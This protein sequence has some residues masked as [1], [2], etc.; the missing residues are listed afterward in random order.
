MRRLF[1]PKLLVL[2]VLGIVATAAAVL[3]GL[4]QYDAWQAGRALAA[5]DLATARPVPLDTV[6]G[7]DATFQG[8][9]VGRPVSLT[10]QWVAEATLLVQHRAHGGRDGS[11]VVTPVAVCDSRATC[12]RAPAI[13]VVRGWLDEADDAPPPPTGAVRVV[14]WLQPGEGSGVP[15]PDPTDDVLPE[16]RVASA[17]QHVDQDLYGG[18]V[19]AETVSTGSATGLEPVTPE[20]LPEVGSS[21]SL[22]NLL[23][24]VEWWAFAAFAGFLWWRWVRDELDAQDAPAAGGRPEEGA[25]RQPD[26]ADAGIASAS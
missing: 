12:A 3:L 4:W 11:W 26:R 21:T 2:H 20:S 22:R 25:D 14:G 24:A 23:Y 18:F 15:D 7:P 13:L 6:L 16:L 19:I 10:G 17:I 8:R 9:D 1:S 5:Q